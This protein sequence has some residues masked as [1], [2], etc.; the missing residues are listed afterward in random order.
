MGIAVSGADDEVA[1]PM[2]GNSAVFDLRGTIRN[3]HHV[4]DLA[5]T[6]GPVSPP[7]A[8]GSAGAQSVEEFSFEPATSLEE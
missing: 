7:P 6:F 5:P 3:H 1:F 8:V 2:A 4:F